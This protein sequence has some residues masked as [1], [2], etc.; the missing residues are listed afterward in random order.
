[1]QKCTQIIHK[2]LDIEIN[3]SIPDETIIYIK[4]IHDNIQMFINYKHLKNI[5]LPYCHTCHSAQGVTIN[6][7]FTIF[8]TNIAYCDR[9]WIW[10]AITRAE[11]LK[12]ITIFQHSDDECKMLEKC[13]LKQYINLKIET[14][15]KTQ[16]ILAGRI[17][18]TDNKYIFPD[19]CIDN[20]F[21]QE[22]LS[23]QNF[24]C[25]MCGCLFDFETKDG[26]VNSNLT[27]DRLN[28]MYTHTKDNCKLAC[29]D[30]NRLK[31]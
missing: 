18:K 17:T 31:K 7:P 4:N 30:C 22:R 14:Y 28:N 20:N 16:D 5:S 19:N 2:I 15:Y 10:T 13:K 29:N 25:Y 23:E 3:E 24:N 12:D 27:V 1:M 6:K 11:H 9:R 8:D 26:T 21:I